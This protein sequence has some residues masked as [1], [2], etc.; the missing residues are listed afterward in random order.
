MTGNTSDEDIDL[1]SI[2]GTIHLDTGWLYVFSERIII[3]VGLST[4]VATTVLE[5]ER[6]TLLVGINRIERNM[7]NASDTV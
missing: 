1:Q 4:S 6:E 7:P 5:E 2:D 3:L